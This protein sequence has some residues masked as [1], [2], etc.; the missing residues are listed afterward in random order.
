[1]DPESPGTSYKTVS[2]PATIDQDLAEEPS[3]DTAE[4]NAPCCRDA[5]E[6]FQ[7][8]DQ[9]VLQ[10]T[11][12][13]QG[14]ARQFCTEWFKGRPW[15]VLC[16]TKMKAFCN[17]CHYCVKRDILIDKQGDAAFIDMGYD[18]WKK[19]LDGFD[20]H[21]KSAMH[22]ETVLKINSLRLLSVATQLSSQLQKDQ[23][24]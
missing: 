7:V 12:K 15:L 21:V 1:L 5:V 11:M 17:F 14:P 13:L 6:S 23:Q 20:K 8:S 10:K 2:L 16:M 9:V 22:R 4:C 24:V 18:H 19:A 3:A